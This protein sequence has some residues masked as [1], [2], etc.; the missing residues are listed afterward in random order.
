MLFEYA[1]EL[2]LLGHDVEVFTTDTGQERVNSGG[3]VRELDGVVVN[4]YGWGGFDR[5]TAFRYA[6]PPRMLKDLVRHF[7]PQT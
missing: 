1:R 6:L 7:D 3:A 2:V 4:V 5:E